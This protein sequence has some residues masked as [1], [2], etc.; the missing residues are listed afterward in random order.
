MRVGGVHRLSHKQEPQEERVSLR[1]VGDRYAEGEWLLQ[2]HGARRFG[3]GQ[4]QLRRRRNLE[5]RTR[6]RTMVN[7]MPTMHTRSLENH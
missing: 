7:G 4:L 5:K 3:D 2:L 6:Y 1:C